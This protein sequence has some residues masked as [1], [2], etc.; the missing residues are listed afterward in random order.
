MSLT[1]EAL[2]GVE[3]LQDVLNRLANRARETVDAEFAA[4]STF[5]D[6]GQLERFIFA[7]IDQ[8]TTG[9]LGKPPTGRGLLGELARHTRPIRLEDLQLDPRFTGWPASH[10]DMTAFL[11]VPIRAVGRTIGSLY[12]TRTRGKPPFT[13]ADELAATFMAMHAAA[14]VSMAL[15]RARSD[16]VQLL[17]ERNRIAH[18]LHDGTIQSLYAIGLEVDSFRHEYTLPD[19][20]VTA[21]D[22][23]VDRISGLIGDIRGYITVLEAE[24]P[25]GAPD[26]ARD[27]AFII[28]RL[29]PPGIDTVMNIRALAAQELAPRE[30]EDLVFISRE[31]ISNAVRHGSPTK[32]AIDLR[33]TAHEVALTVQDN[34][35]GYDAASVRTGLGMVTMRTRAERLGGTLWTMSIPGMGTTVRVTV[36]RGDDERDD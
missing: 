11:G 15:A 6:A 16:R 23:C 9:R 24:T 8:E 32:V 21:L 13:A 36:R 20:C 31:A 4:I 18:D 22:G 27:L 5:D 2:V 33:A 35:I 12:M 19:A 7:G 17:E 34:G 29:V 25:T 14:S 3:N 30:V 28:Q 1:S 10:P 26:L